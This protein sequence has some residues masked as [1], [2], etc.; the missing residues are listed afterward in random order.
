MLK[1]SALI[2]D[3]DTLDAAPDV[4]CPACGKE[5]SVR[6]SADVAVGTVEDCPHCG[7]LLQCSDQEW[8]RWWR[9]KVAEDFHV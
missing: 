6:D 7:A 2:S 8:V 5:F 1:I 4:E 9:W 3:G